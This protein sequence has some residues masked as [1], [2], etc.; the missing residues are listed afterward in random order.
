MHTAVQ[1][2]LDLK[3]GMHGINGVVIPSD[4]VIDSFG[5]DEQK[6]I[7]YCIQYAMKTTGCNHA[8]LANL[9]E[10]NKSQFSLLWSG[11]RGIPMKR[12]I[13][14]IRAT[15][16][17][18]LLK[19]HAKHVGLVLKTKHEWGLLVRRDKSNAERVAELEAENQALKNRLAPYESAIGE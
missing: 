18:A 12:S 13:Q 14:F 10:M 9:A 1:Q 6:A 16:N 11:Q 17:A 19:F 7:D 4:D 15:G 8:A 5:D 2:E 3:R